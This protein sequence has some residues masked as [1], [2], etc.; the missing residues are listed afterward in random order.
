MAFV[1]KLDPM[2]N[3]PIYLDYFAGT[4]G[5]NPA[6]TAATDLKYSDIDSDYNLSRSKFLSVA[7]ELRSKNSRVS[8]T[9]QSILSKEADDLHVL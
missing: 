8:L 9:S 5:G 7:K 4:V 3:N 2:A 6:D 1:I